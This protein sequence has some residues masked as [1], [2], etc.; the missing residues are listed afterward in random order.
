MPYSIYSVELINLNNNLKI[1]KTLTPQMDIPWYCC[2]LLP[3]SP[4]KKHLK[5]RLKSTVGKLK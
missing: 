5:K 2:I 3:K 1:G 4:T